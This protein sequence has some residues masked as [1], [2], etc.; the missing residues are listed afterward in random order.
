MTSCGH[1]ELLRL[2]G[3]GSD[4]CLLLFQRPSVMMQ[5]HFTVDFFSS[6]I[7]VTPEMSLLMSFTCCSAAFKEERLESDIR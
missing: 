7:V 2:L 3:R 5:S 1:A 6:F 4:H